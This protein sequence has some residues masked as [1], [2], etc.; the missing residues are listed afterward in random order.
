MVNGLLT[1][2]DLR[3]STG[4]DRVGDIRRCLEKQ[5]VEYFWG[6]D[7]IWTTVELVNAAKQ[8]D[9]ATVAAYLPEMV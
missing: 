2:A 5:G 8:K 9:R 1:T 4:Y 3:A 7:G 6:K